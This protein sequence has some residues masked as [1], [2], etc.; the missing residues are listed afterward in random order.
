MTEVR[1][2]TPRLRGCSLPSWA[3]ISCVT[4]SLRYSCSG[5]PL[6]FA[7]GSTASLTERV[8]SPNR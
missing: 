7:K 4:P 8:E 5:S 1:A 6:R 2:M 3:I